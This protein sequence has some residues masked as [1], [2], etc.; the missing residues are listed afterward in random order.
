VTEKDN[1]TNPGLKRA[2]LHPLASFFAGFRFLTVIPVSWKS[3]DD[4]QFFQS[5]LI[6]FPF[7]GLLIGSVTAFFTSL[8]ITVLPVTVLAVFAMIMLAGLS[9]CLHLDGLADSGDGLLSSRPRE[10]ALE[11]MRDSHT[12]A[13]G[14]IAVVFVLLGKYAA[15]SSLS[16]TTFLVA[17][18]LIPLAGRTAILISMAILPYARKGDGLGKLFYSKD[19]R[20]VS[21][22]GIIFCG[23]IMAFVSFNTSLFC[24]AAILITVAFFSFWCFKKLG[25]AT[26]DTL[27][28]VCEM[29]E[30]TV[31]VAMVFISRIQ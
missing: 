8:F 20:I 11:I 30:F 14:M 18:F 5:S 2:L 1:N 13:M 9:G 6:W 28:A 7:I 15:L 25:G 10:R 23:I 16:G 26:G 27:G 24:I 3:E 29:T 4:G 21:V 31:A 12:G 19:S 17:L 22:L